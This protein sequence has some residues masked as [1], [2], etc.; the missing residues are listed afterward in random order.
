[1]ELDFDQLANKS[2]TELFNILDQL[3][4][5]Y[6]D[7]LKSSAVVEQEL[8]GISLEILK[9]QVKKKSLKMLLDKSRHN[10]KQI[11]SSKRIVNSMAW[12]ARNSGT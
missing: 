2:S 4:K 8:E 11:T 5:D 12:A 1:M 7:A 9:L 10:E 6:K 3:E